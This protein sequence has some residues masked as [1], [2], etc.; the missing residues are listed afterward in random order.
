MTML[1][2]SAAE[3]LARDIVYIIVI[4]RRKASV[5]SLDV[6]DVFDGEVAGE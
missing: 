1:R 5:L 3:E 4:I 6:K 2:G